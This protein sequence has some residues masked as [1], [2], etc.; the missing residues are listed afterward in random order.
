MAG[1]IKEISEQNASELVELAT[2]TF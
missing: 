1:I 2:R